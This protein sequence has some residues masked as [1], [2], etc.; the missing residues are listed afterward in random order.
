MLTSTCQ[1]SETDKFSS[2][3]RKEHPQNMQSINR[4]RLFN[5]DNFDTNKTVSKS[6]AQLTSAYSAASTM[7]WSSAMVGQG[8]QHNCTVGAICRPWPTGH[9]YQAFARA[10]STIRSRSEGLH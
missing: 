7:S 1:P 6:P 9:H 10:N 5:S 4:K 2:I 3:G 8:Q